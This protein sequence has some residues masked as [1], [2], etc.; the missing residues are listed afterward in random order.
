MSDT[1][2]YASTRR[3]ARADGGGGETE[4]S[5]LELCSLEGVCGQAGICHHIARCVFTTKI[6][7]HVHPP[8][9]GNFDLGS[10]CT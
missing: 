3:Q 9:P 7:N 2:N 5:V 1:A 8:P 4:S 6:I 10:A